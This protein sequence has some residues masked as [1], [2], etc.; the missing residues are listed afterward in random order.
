MNRI[1]WGFLKTC[2]KGNGEVRKSGRVLNCFPGNTEGEYNLLGEK[3]TTKS[4]ICNR[5][6]STF[7]QKLSRSDYTSSY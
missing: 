1:F 3:K 5:F 4:F 2:F 6:I 7:S